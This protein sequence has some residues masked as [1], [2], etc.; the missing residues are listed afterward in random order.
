[1][2][3]RDFVLGGC[4]TLAA[5]VILATP[6]KAEQSG[7][8]RA[9][10]RLE[11]FP[12]LETSASLAAWRRYV[13][14]RFAQAMPGSARELVLRRIEQHH[15][16]EHGE[17]FTLLFTAAMDATLPGGTQRLRHATTGQ[18]IPIFLQPAGND[19]DGRALYRADFNRLV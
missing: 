17:Q 14:E 1:M 11:R 7:A 10:R 2:D 8:A 12:D 18:K 13:G 15:A 4:T 19:L 5:T 3:K 6:A 16:D 9:V